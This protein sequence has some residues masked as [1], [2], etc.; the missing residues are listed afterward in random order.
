MVK[1]R[2]TRI[3]L[4]HQLPSNHRRMILR[5]AQRGHDRF[6]F[7]DGYDDVL[8][9]ADSLENAGKT[10]TFFIVTGWIGLPGF[11][12]E[13]MLNELVQRGHALGNHTAHHVLLHR[14]PHSI[15]LRE[16]EEAQERLAEIGYR[17]TR[18][19][20]PYGLSDR[21][22]RAVVRQMGLEPRGIDAD[23]VIPIA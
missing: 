8:E 9:A 17:P 15:M 3:I 5:Y 16:V 22:T 1:K 2:D 13:D 7:D 20:F 12:T 4:F 23:E 6:D 11:A 21:A 19:A 10:G 18:L 14:V